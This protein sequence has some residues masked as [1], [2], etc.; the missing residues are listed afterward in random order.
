M[1]VFTTNDDNPVDGMMKLPAMSRPTRLFRLAAI[2][3]VAMMMIVA[4]LVSSADE[5]SEQVAD[6]ILAA[7][8]AL[9]EASLQ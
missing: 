9:E 8:E 6:H 4:P 7:E 1:S 5:D 3:Y 2:P